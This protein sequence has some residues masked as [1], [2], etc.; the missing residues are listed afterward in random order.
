M[1]ILVLS[2]SSPLKTDISE[3]LLFESIQKKIDV[4][5]SLT[6]LTKSEK[7]VVI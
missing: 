1:V 5:S 2:F 4:L 3:K 6:A 7:T